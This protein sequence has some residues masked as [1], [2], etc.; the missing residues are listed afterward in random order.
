MNVATDWS[1]IHK[2]K[3]CSIFDRS[4]LE[5]VTVGDIHR[6]NEKYA[7]VFPDVLLME[8]AQA[9][10]PKVMENIA[11]IEDFLIIS[12][13]AKRITLFDLVPCSPHQIMKKDLGV[14]ILRT[15]TEDSN[16]V[17]F[18]PYDK[19]ERMDLINWAKNG[20][21]EEYYEY[22]EE[23]EEMFEKRYVRRSAADVVEEI[24]LQGIR[25]GYRYLPKD[26]IEKRT[27]GLHKAYRK[28]YG[29]NPS[30]GNELQDVIG[31]V[32]ISLGQTS[33]IEIIESLSAVYG[34]DPLWAK[35][36]IELRP[37]Y[38]HPDDYAKYSYYFYF[39]TMCSGFCGLMMGKKYLRDWQYMFYLPFCSVFSADKKFFKNLRDAMKIIG[40]D[41]NLGIN[42]SDRIHIWGEDNMRIPITRGLQQ[43]KQ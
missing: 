28:K 14:S 1:I 11:K 43:P 9:E 3:E 32:K 42:I 13:H 20:S 31:L 17:Y 10:N 36:Q 25:E 5:R 23:F 37:S 16:L 22:F 34:F 39:V 2:G 27:K 29:F 35:K 24:R 8:C 12:I 15:P 41:E 4:I 21:A 19:E 40:T 26:E 30:Y 38:P 18:I 6:L 7:F 33:I